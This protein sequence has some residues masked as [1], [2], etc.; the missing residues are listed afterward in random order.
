VCLRFSTELGAQHVYQTGF[1]PIARDLD[2]HRQ[3]RGKVLI[4]PETTMETLL[5]RMNA[6]WRFT[7]EELGSEDDTAE[8]LTPNSQRRLPVALLKPSGELVLASPESELGAGTHGHLIAFVAPGA[9]DGRR[10]G[11]GCLRSLT[12]PVRSE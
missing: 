12:N 7:V 9:T 11:S 10:R 5:E 1:D 2:L 8:A 3:W 4:G 6:G